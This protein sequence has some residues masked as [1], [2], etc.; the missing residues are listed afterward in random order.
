[1]ADTVSQVADNKIEFGLCSVYYA[2]ITG[3]DAQTKKYTYA[4]PVPIPGGVSVTFSA[5]GDSNPFYADNIVYFNVKTNAG[6]EGDLEIATIPDSFKID[7]LGEVE[8][9]GMLAENADAQGK[10]FALMFQFE[11][12]VSCRRHVMYRC[13]AG[14]PDIASSTREGSTTP[15]TS[16][17]TITCMA[18]ENDHYIKNSL[19]EAKNKVRYANWNTQVQEPIAEDAA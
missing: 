18:R 15:N 11:G 4:T 17:L 13:S 7:V 2:V 14:R 8:I 19:L 3:Y 5:S 1:M 16:K 12:D 9:D 10:E 6:Y